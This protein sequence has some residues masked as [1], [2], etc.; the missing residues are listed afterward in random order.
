MKGKEKR[1]KKKGF[2]SQYYL[3]SRRVKVLALLNNSPNLVQANRCN[4]IKE[5]L[6]QTSN[7]LL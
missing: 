6:P 3:V 1:K 5:L 7:L 2:I 4:R